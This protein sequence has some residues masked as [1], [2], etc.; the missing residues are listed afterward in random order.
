MLPT[1]YKCVQYN[2]Y[3]FYGYTSSLLV[4]VTK[5]ILSW[6][7]LHVCV[8]VCERGREGGREGGNVREEEGG[9]EKEKV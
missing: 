4:R 6:V 1:K 7:A 8:W 9:G 5:V 3:T 2:L